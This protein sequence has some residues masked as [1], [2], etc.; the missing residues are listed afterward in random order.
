MTFKITLW[1]FGLLFIATLWNVAS[2]YTAMGEVNVQ[3]RFQ[4]IGLLSGG[5]KMAEFPLPPRKPLQNSEF[6]A[7]E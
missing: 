7:A 4:E 3:D 1:A 6:A 5:E 2:A